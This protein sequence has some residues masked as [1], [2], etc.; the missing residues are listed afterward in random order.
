MPKAKLGSGT[1]FKAVA[2]SARKSGADNPD[3]VAAAVGVKKYGQK[4]MTALAVK[5]RKR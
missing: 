1:R 5:G 4:R 2:A 3:A